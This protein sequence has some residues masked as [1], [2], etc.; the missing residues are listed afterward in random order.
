MD[1]RLLHLVIVFLLGISLFSCSSKVT[2]ISK[3]SKLPVAV[4]NHAVIVFLDTRCEHT[5]SVVPV[6]YHL[7]QI[8][9]TNDQ[10]ILLI[11]PNSN[12]VDSMHHFIHDHDLT[13]WRA[14]LDQMSQIA[15]VN[16]VTKNPYAL[17]VDASNRVMYQG[18]LVKTDQSDKWDEAPVIQALKKIEKGAKKYPNTILNVG[19]QNQ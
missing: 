11:N 16:Q 3:I 14:Y 10:L 5:L 15:K 13:Q 6:L 1:T 19:C 9:D 18:A 2:G 7:Q 17:I 12:S 4:K 8:V